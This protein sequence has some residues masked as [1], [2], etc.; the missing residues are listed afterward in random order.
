MINSHGHFTVH[1]DNALGHDVSRKEWRKDC[2]MDI[3]GAACHSA[4][5]SLKGEQNDKKLLMLPRRHML[6]R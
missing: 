1:V 5:L 2:G 3:S 4:E 6:D